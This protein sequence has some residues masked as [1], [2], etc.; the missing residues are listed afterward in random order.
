MAYQNNIRTKNFDRSIVNNLEEKT[1]IIY[2]TAFKQFLQTSCRKE[3]DSRNTKAREKLTYLSKQQ[4]YELSTDVYDE[5]IRR[6]TK[7][8]D[9]SFLIPNE[10]FHPKRNQARQK[11]STLSISRFVD[12]LGDVSFELERRF[13]TLVENVAT[14]KRDD[15]FTGSCSQSLSDTTNTL[16]NSGLP[17]PKTFRSDTIIPNKSTIVEEGSD[18][19]VSPIKTPVSSNSFRMDNLTSQE[20]SRSLDKKIENYNFKLKEID[21]YENKISTKKHTDNDKT[22]PIDNLKKNVVTSDYEYRI[23]SL[24]N[25][26]FSLECQLNVVNAK[27]TESEQELSIIKKT[28]EKS[29]EDEIQLRKTLESNLKELQ[30]SNKILNEEIQ[31]LNK[32]QDNLNKNNE[33]YQLLLSNYEKLKS[34]MEEQ[35]RVTNNVKREA[36][37][38]LEEMRSLSEKESSSWQQIET[39]SKQVS[40]LQDEVRE[41]KNQYSKAKSQ[42]LNLKGMYSILNFGVSLTNFQIA[43]DDLLHAG[44]S[45]EQK[46]VL[47]AMKDVILSVKSINMNL[48]DNKHKSIF[49]DPQK[50]SIIEK[51][52]LRMSATANN[53]MI[54]SKNHAL[55]KGLS[56]VSLLDAAAFNLTD[57]IVK[58]VKLVKLKPS[59]TTDSLCENEDPDNKELTIN[60]SSTL[61]DLGILKD[62]SSETQPQDT[63]SNVYL[64]KLDT[65]KVHKTTALKT[66]LDSDFDKNL[67][68]FKNFL[69]KQT[70]DIVELI[71]SFL[72]SIRADSQIKKLK[73]Y[74]IKIITVVQSIVSETFQ[75]IAIEKDENLREKISTIVN[76]LMNCCSRFEELLTDK[77]EN[78]NIDKSFKQN[79]AGIAF[80]VAKQ[81]KELVRTINGESENI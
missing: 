57:T 47:E 62:K 54:A 14:S 30:Q 28:Y 41:W 35:Q 27:L 5:L 56:P 37:E 15:F 24:Q 63:S 73:E 59:D 78:I 43:I 68:D 36:K 65:S 81:T 48:E 1:N 64:T 19:D 58:L 38:F 8:L 17:V 16:L 67:Q 9:A 20:L 77:I 13:P 7:S 72:S 70:E 3:L 32:K 60:A 2:Y 50:N 66:L 53:L 55:N 12:L 61:P 26:I 46:S 76:G 23:A 33:K 42:L 44:R 49:D 74:M 29:I 4:F 80:D 31:V 52:K 18:V 22:E 51:L 25:K 39:L 10:A 34:E 40:V 71:Q 69:E 6:Q 75:V 79:L 11:L 45:P 21:Q